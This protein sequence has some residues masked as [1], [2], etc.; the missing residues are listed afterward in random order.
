MTDENDDQQKKKGYLEK[1]VSASPGSASL[2]KKSGMDIDLSSLTV[3]GWIL[4]IL[5]ILVAGAAVLIPLLMY[6]EAGNRTSGG[7]ARAIG[8]PIAIV[9]GGA[10]FW[11]GKL[12][13]TKLGLPL[14][15]SK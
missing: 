3:A 2:Q 13:L 5:T 15:R 11:V 1:L 7:I 10:T 9:G 4:A 8:I 12:L 6:T 14:T